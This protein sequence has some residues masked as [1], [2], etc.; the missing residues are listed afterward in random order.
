MQQ[1]TGFQKLVFRTIASGVATEHLGDGL[2][3]V[4]QGVLLGIELNDALFK[5][6]NLLLNHLDFLGDFRFRQSKS[7]R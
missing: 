1:T 2:F 4:R 6:L 5:L 3:V 7:V